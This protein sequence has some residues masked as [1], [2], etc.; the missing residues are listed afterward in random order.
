MSRSWIALGE[1]VLRFHGQIEP[2]CFIMPDTIACCLSHVTG[3]FRP[4]FGFRSVTSS[5]ARVRIVSPRL[6]PRRFAVPPPGFCASFPP[7]DA[8]NDDDDR[9]VPG[10]RDDTTRHDTLRSLQNLRLET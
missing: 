3:N 4:T 9:R 5:R 1:S 2:M 8:T 7:G 10:R 6:L